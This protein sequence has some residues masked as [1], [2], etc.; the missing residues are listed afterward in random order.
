MVREMTMERGETVEPAGE[1]KKKIRGGEAATWSERDRF[2]V[3]L[4]F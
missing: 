3:S 1:E 2:R 4:L